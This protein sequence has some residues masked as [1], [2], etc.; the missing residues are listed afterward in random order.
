[1]EKEAN[2]LSNATTLRDVLSEVVSISSFDGVGVQDQLISITN[3]LNKISSFGDPYSLLYER[4]LSLK[5][6]FTDIFSEAKQLGEEVQHDPVHLQKVEDKLSTLHRLCQKHRVKN[7]DGLIEKREYLRMKCEGVGTLDE[8]IILLDKMFL[9]LDKKL[10]STAFEIRNK[11]EAACGPLTN[12]LIERS[13]DLG[14]EHVRFSIEISHL[15]NPTFN[16]TEKVELFFSANK[17]IDFASFA[18]VASGGELS[19]IMLVVKSIM[20]EKTDLPTLI[21]DEID[22]GVS[23]EMAKSMG[24]RMYK[25]SRNLQLISISHLPQIAALADQH[26]KVYKKVINDSTHTFL[27][28]LNEDQRIEELAEMLSGKEIKDS[29]IVHARELRNV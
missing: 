25:M 13:R 7:A 14:M 16:G 26:Y 9:V 20:S 18:K 10:K 28:L 19:R 2:L 15:S 24:N 1:L 3:L 27:N 17:G 22:T 29:A 4:I 11:R 8:K 5:I 21:L 6:E 23:G 12:M